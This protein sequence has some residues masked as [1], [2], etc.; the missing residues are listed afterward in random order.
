MPRRAIGGGKGAEATLEG[1]G[2]SADAPGVIVADS[3]METLQQVSALLG[4][5]R[6]WERFPAQV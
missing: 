2:V 1:A 4:A 5:H 6:V 3:G